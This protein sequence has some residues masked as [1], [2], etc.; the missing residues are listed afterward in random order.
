MLNVV[1]LIGYSLYVDD[2]IICFKGRHVDKMIISYNN[3][4]GIFQVYSL[5]NRGYTYAL[6]IEELNCAK[7]IHIDWTF[8][9]A[10]SCISLTSN[11][12]Q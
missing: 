8:N 7:G 11:T 4:G 6:F 12:L 9:F 10:C 5:C 2:K 1:W 3:E